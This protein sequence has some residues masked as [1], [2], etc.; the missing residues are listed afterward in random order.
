METKRYSRRIY[1]SATYVAYICISLYIYVCHIE[2]TYLIETTSTRISAILPA[3]KL[4]VINCGPTLCYV[5]NEIWYISQID[6]QF[7]YLYYCYLYIFYIYM[8]CRN[9]IYRSS[10]TW[11]EDPWIRNDG[12]EANL[13][14][15]AS[16]HHR[17]LMSNAR[18]VLLVCILSNSHSQ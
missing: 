3:S 4:A 12:Y 1:V 10:I 5:N 2:I 13:P 15:N 18:M 9:M 14:T 6:I 17:I 8:W 11:V 16:L 7:V